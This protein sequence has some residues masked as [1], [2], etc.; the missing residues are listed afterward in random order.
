MPK[1]IKP[2]TQFKQANVRAILEECREALEPIAEKYGLTLDRK[3]RT[4]QGDSLPVMY[5]LLIKQVTEDGTVLTAAGKDFQTH[6]PMY[7]FEKDDLGKTF[8]THQGTYRISG[9]KPKSR[10]YP[11]LGECVKS[12]KTYKFMVEQVKAAFKRA[13]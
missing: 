13:A 1:E 8:T 6:A 11:I 3:G 9:W 5:Q 10:K 2:V 4:Y 7:G 12:G